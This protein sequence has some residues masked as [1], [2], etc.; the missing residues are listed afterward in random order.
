M[1]SKIIQVISVIIFLTG[2][3]CLGGVLYFVVFGLVHVGEWD[4]FYTWLIIIGLPC[5][6]VGVIL[7]NKTI[8]S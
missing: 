4:P 8:E 7:V 2:L 6:I 3:I 1:S 5:F